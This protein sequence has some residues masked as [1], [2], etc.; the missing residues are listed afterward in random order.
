M[1]EELLERI[2]LAIGAFVLFSGFILLVSFVIQLI[3]EW[4]VDEIDYHE[5][6][7]RTEYERRKHQAY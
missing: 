1:M 4:I 3:I 2:M 6:K 5:W 7:R